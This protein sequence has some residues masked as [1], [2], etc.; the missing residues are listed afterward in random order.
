MIA[1]IKHKQETERLRS[2]ASYAILDTFPEDSYDAITN[3]AAQ[4]CKVPI[5]IITMVEEERQWFK[6]VCGLGVNETSRDVSFCG[7]AINSEND[8][9][10]IPDATKDE[11]FFDN[12]LVTS[13]PYINFYAGVPILG[14]DGLPMGT[15]CS[16]DT[17]PR[18]LT[19]FQKDALKT[20]AKQVS[21]LLELRKKNLL[22]HGVV[23]K[24]KTKNQELDKF[25]HVAAHDLKSPLA[26]ISGLI[27]IFKEDY[28]EEIDRNGLDLLNMMAESSEKLRTLIDGLL[29]HSRADAFEAEDT[30]SIL[31]VDLKKELDGM[32]LKDRNFKFQIITDLPKLRVNKT[33]L[34]QVLINLIS[35]SIKYCDKPETKV[36]LEI[37]E[38]NQFYTFRLIDNGP[39]IRVEF[40]ER[41]F[42]LFE[43]FASEDKYGERGNGIGL[44]TVK[45]VVE[46]MGGQI[47]IESDVSQGATFQFT[48][49]K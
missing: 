9:F 5:C 8:I 38:K 1:P 15:L 21:S 35:N 2:L 28:A 29:K 48:I 41:V 46:K 30:E 10:I 44:A 23:E 16:I 11:R 47:F 27:E 31:L 18:E 3:L 36:S 43:V 24:L 45:K 32:F 26:G 13:E 40:Q 33:A 49:E 4:I 12:P 17:V 14:T 19:T 42:N 22:L 39:G 34:I 25:A 37:S 20:L 6:S 7:H